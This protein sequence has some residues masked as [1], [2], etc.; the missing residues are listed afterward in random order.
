MATG[1]IIARILTQYS[2]KGSKQAQRDIKKLG[3]TFDDYAKK[4]SR[5]VGL[6]AIAA[7]AAAV[8]IG[9]DSVMAASDVAQQFGA[10]DAVF[11]SNSKQLKDFAKTM[12]EYGLSTA[13]SARFSAL[14]G[15]QLTGLGLSQQ[16]AI[17]RTQKLQILSADLAA[18]YGGTTADAVAALS[19]TFKGEYNPIERYGV[20]IRKSDITARVAAKGLKGLTG[21]ALKAAEA[22]AAYELILSKTT[23]AQ[24]QSGR[25]FNTL[26]AQLQRLDAS[27]T[28]IQASLGEALLPVVQEFAGYIL[29]DVI[30]GIQSWV[31]TN[32]T[33]LAES[34]KRAARLAGEFLKVAGKVAAWATN[35]IGAVKAIAAVIATIF[36]VNKVANFATSIASMV[37]LLKGLK[38]QADL[39]NAST[40]KI[41][42]VGK[43]GIAAVV[44]SI[45][46][47]G[48]TELQK[49][50]QKQLD[51]IKDLEK[52]ESQLFT[53]QLRRDPLTQTMVKRRIRALKEEIALVEKLAREQSKFVGKG[54]IPYSIGMYTPAEYK[55]AQA[56]IDRTSKIEQAAAAA[57]LRSTEKGLAADAKREKVLKRLKKLNVTV[58]GSKASI[59]G[60]TP[61]STLEAAEQEAISFRAAEL[62]LL[63]AKDNALETEKLKKLRERIGLQEI[64]NKLAERYSDILIALADNT[65][66][67]KDIIALAGK[68]KTTTDVAKM[69]VQQVL[70]LGSLETGEAK[71]A[72][73]MTTWGMTNEQAKRYIAF[74]DM[75]KKGSYSTADIERVGAAH[76]L[77]AEEAKK[78]YT[79]VKLIMDQ[80]LSDADILAIKQAYSDTNLQ[81]VQMIESIGVPVKVTGNILDPSLIARLESHW[82][83]AKKAMDDYYKALG[84]YNNNGIQ[85]PKTP[86]FPA[87]VPPT[88]VVPPKVDGS[89]VGSSRTDSA[90]EAASKSAAIAYAVAKATGDQAKA[91]IAAAEVRPSDLALGESGA[92]GAASIARQL[93]EA[94]NAVKIASSLAAFK[95][96]EAADLI[97]SRTDSAASIDYDERFRFQ[98]FQGSNTMDNAKSMMAGGMNA[99]GNQTINVTVNGSVTA[100]QD[101]VQTI[102]N[103]LLRGQYN[104]QSLDLQ[105]V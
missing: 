17:E 20:A 40:S 79:Y 88:V 98:A 87:V 91:A 27:Y 43:A 96:K 48:A 41:G 42:L 101:L 76:G 18:T 39:T 47:P 64:S 4:A 44:A 2:D 59:K 63:K 75:I 10:L 66:S 69:Y 90:A 93:A 26:A 92:I 60:V 102:R 51:N 8:K 85:M 11:K 82:I 84:A 105:A 13:D 83:A 33:Q 25:E 78:Y 55:V 80:E 6:V 32:R 68:W 56:E 28:N 65:I 34:L 46:L 73:L 50:A 71:V 49:A 7:G 100:E 104:G 81:I 1:A 12:V 3:K 54:T 36:V 86:S 53:A 5:A 14:L 74:T 72:M 37:T 31:D 62:L 23:A 45:A 29:K 38:T 57:A 89:G 61:I 52:L 24:G 94:E 77:N 67:D 99:T 97:A 30:P 22:Q 16:D 58:G 70:G 9:K 35:N 103:G 21:E 15:T 95:A 19:S